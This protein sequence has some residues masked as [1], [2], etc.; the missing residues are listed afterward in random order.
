MRFLN[1]SALGAVG[2]LASSTKGALTNHL[3]GGTVTQEGS[4]NS[5]I[6]DPIDGI[7]SSYY[8]FSSADASDYIQVD[9]GSSQTINSVAFLST[10][11]YGNTSEIEVYIGDTDTTGTYETSNCL[12]HK[13][14]RIGAIPCTS[15]CVGRYFILKI[16]PLATTSTLTRIAEM[17]AWT[18]TIA[19]VSM[20]NYVA[21]GLDQTEGGPQPFDYL[22]GPQD[23]VECKEFDVTATPGTFSFEL[24]SPGWV[25]EVWFYIGTTAT[26]ANPTTMTVSVVD[27]LA[28]TTICG[29]ADVTSGYGS[30]ACPS[31]T[32]AISSITVELAS[33]G[34]LCRMGVF[35]QSCASLV[36][37][38]TQPA[39]STTTVA[40]DLLTETAL[41]ITLPIVSSTPDG[42]HTPTWKLYYTS[43]GSEK[44]GSIT[45]SS[46]EMTLT[47]NNLSLTDRNTQFASGTDYYLQ[48]TYNDDSGA[49]TDQFPL[50]INWSDDCRTATV[51]SAVLT[52][53]TVKWGT[54]L[55]Y[56]WSVSAF[57]DSVD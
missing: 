54:D 37:V 34:M 40:F 16:D 47:H 25:E 29:D 9:M 23:V 2:L 49:Q 26:Y 21:T 41:I 3:T 39:P 48:A 19:S 50:V 38:I 42:C 1:P 18:E 27:A 10:G 56:S 31:S 32:S 51:N 36:P 22:F 28:A 53:P 55:T 7:P 15:A 44:G 12:C 17:F 8:F 35:G 13:G 45:F 57:V 4:L 43:D 20:L 24:E 14:K 33:N 30:V 46:T 5:S 6:N 52:Y 11:A